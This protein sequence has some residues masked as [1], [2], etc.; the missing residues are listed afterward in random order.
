MSTMFSIS[1][2]HRLIGQ[3]DLAPATPSQPRKRALGVGGLR[4]QHVEAALC[5]DAPPP[6]VQHQIGAQGVIHRVHHALQP[7]EILQI[8]GAGVHIGVH[9][10]GRRVDDASRVAVFRRCLLI[11]DGVAPAAAGHAVYL[12]GMQLRRGGPRGLG[13]AAGAQDEHLLAGKRQSH[14]ADE[15]QHPRQVRVVAHQPAVPVHHG[16]HRADG[17]R[18]LAEL[19]QIGDDLPPYRG[20]SR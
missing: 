14:A 8:H 4:R 15:R 11:G 13:G 3:V 5:G 20:W 6:G 7:G 10:A 1:P 9:A 12:R 16:V 17:P 18:R 2:P 19:V